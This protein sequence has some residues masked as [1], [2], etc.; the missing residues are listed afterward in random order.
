MNVGTTGPTDLWGD[1][2]PPAHG[3]TRAVD[4]GPVRIWLRGVENEVWVGHYGAAAG[5]A[6]REAPP[7]TPPADIE[8]SRWALRD[9]PHKLRIRPTFPN[10]PLVVKLEHPFTLLRQA[11]ARVY[12]RVPA[13]VCLEVVEESNATA[14]VLCEIPTGHL[15]ET[16]WGD[17]TEG[18]L[19]YW[20]PTLGKRTLSPEFFE[21]NI[22]TS[23]VQ[24]ANRSTDDLRV[25]KLVLRVEHLSIY[26]KDGWLWAEEV[27]VHY[28]GAEEGS[29][30]HMDDTP[31]T[32]V[33]DAR[34]ISPAR[35]QVRSFRART[36]SRL[37]AL[38]GLCG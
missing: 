26:E 31:P 37:K 1:G 11:E 30:I 12:M 17:F 19:A 21:P 9:V 27:T 3:E 20:L 5:E 23:P 24:L 33:P 18:E 29:E 25:E 14:S 28:R 34:E 15:S 10:R 38:S 7:E 36:F 4:V 16:W 13:W 8:W 32:E 2:L 6:P 35:A 22:I